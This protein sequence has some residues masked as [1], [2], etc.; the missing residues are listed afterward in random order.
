V[1]N[2]TRGGGGKRGEGKKRGEMGSSANVGDAGEKIKFLQNRRKGENAAGDCG[3]EAGVSAGGEKMR[4]KRKGG[5][6]TGA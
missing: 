2:L 6:V 1:L 4:T 3:R 5:R